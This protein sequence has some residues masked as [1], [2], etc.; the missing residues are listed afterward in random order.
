MKN[1]NTYILILFATIVICVAIFNFRGKEQFKDITMMEPPISNGFFMRPDQPYVGDSGFFTGM[2]K[3]LSDMFNP[4]I[5]P[6]YSSDFRFYEN[7]P[8]PMTPPQVVGCGGRRGACMGGTQ[9]P[10]ANGLPGIDVSNA[11]IAPVN[12]INFPTR[13]PENEVQQIGVIYKNFGN[14]NDTYYPLYG[15]RNYRNSNQWD[16][17]TQ[18]GQ[19]NV[20]VP[21]ITKNYNNNE[22]G[23]GDEVRIQ[24][25]P[26]V[27]RV[28]VY[29]ND[30][31]IRFLPS[32]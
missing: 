4:L 27:F 9:I 3:R 6:Y 7:V 5:Y 17:Y 2:Q 10:I 16:Y 24:G 28:S 1:K 11:N 19:F 23:E 22:L 12:I 32:Y 13:G 14:E 31:P 26:N 29:Q 18:I 30:S 20:K 15:R 21:V 8:I 25:S